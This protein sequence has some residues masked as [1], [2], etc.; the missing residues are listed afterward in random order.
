[1]SIDDVWDTTDL[2][3]ATVLKASHVNEASNAM[4]NYV[5]KGIGN[6]ELD[7]AYD[8]EDNALDPY[9]KKG[10]LKNKQIYRPEFYGSPSPRMM[11]VSGQTHYRETNNDWS[12]GAVFNVDMVGESK[13]GV[14]GA[15]T[16]IKL[17]HQA[18]VNIMCSFYMFEFGGVALAASEDNRSTE[19]PYIYGRST[20]RDPESEEQANKGYES[21]RAGKVFMQINGQHMQSTKRYIYTSAVGPKNVHSQQLGENLSYV[22]RGFIFLP[23]VGRHQHSIMV[24]YR[25]D[26][27]VHDIGLVFEPGRP[28]VDEYR[29]LD[30]LFSTGSAAEEFRGSSPEAAPSFPKSKHIFFLARNLVVDCHYE[31]NTP[32]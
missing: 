16:R 25:L 32:R 8:F 28:P 4:Q 14:P 1:M 20:I 10:W 9:E 26:A 30:R 17:R 6:H 22:Q 29:I 2:D 13:V 7:N 11:A 18:T 21:L 19:S 27:G 5:N 3:S 24:Q 15:C 12:T 23:M 31:N